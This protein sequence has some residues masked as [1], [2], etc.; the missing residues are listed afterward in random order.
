MNRTPPA[1]VRQQLRGESGFG[2][3]VPECS[4]PYLEW[5]H[6]DPPFAERQHH[7]PNGMVA[8]CPEHHRKA[9]AGAYTVEQFHEFKREAASRAAEV[10]GSFDWLRRDVALV[11]GGVFY[12]ECGVA[13]QVRGR[14]VI[15]F[16]RDEE[17]YALLNV[18]MPQGSP[19]SRVVIEDNFWTKRGNVA[20]LVSPPGGKSLAVSYANGDR[21]S[22]EFG[23]V[24]DRAMLE[25]RFPRAPEALD[26]PVTT[27]AVELVVP[28][29]GLAFNTRETRIG[30]NTISGGLMS[31]C[32]IG[33]SVD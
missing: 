2:C 9:D 29:L 24:A 18:R 22:I 27:V 28:G 25:R 1:D 13:V 20:D 19:S 11:A 17:G 23:E 33:L 4:R 12:V 15:W 6:F 31:H 30:T 3:V 14:P 26:L 10:K 7:D 8:L 21:L 32:G 16:R 5:H